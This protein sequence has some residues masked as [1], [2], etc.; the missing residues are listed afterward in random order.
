MGDW[1]DGTGVFALPRTP[2]PWANAPARGRQRRTCLHAANLDIDAQHL[3]ERHEA[4][5]CE[6]LRSTSGLFYAKFG[7]TDLD[8]GRGK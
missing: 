7:I 5:N 6:K 4:L 8:L 3:W 1:G 2:H